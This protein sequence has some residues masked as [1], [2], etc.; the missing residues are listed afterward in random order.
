[1]SFG[2][3]DLRKRL[4][5]S[6]KQLMVAIGLFA[7]PVTVQLEKVASA[8]PVPARPNP[9]AP[10]SAA[11]PNIDPRTVRLTRFFS[12]LHCPVLSLAD[13]F[14][15]EA[16]NNH[17]DWRLL[18]SISV[19]ESGGGKAYRNNNIF[20]WNKGAQFFPTIRSG[21]KEVAYKLGR[22]PLYKNRDS[23]GKLR[24][25]N[26]EDGYV[27]TVVT[28]MNRISPVVN[29]QPVRHAMAQRQAYVLEQN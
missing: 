6:P 29:L 18:P 12:H 2:Y 28:V 22:S 25:Y 9:L 11:I 14:I 17:L 3:K 1:M 26:P 7:V 21:I 16:D 15:H 19:I 23:V 27:Q 10:K 24:V 20:G 13:D 5:L 8:E 4:A